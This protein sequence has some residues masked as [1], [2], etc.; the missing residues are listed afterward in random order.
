MPETH[1]AEVVEVIR[2]V[3]PVEYVKSRRAEEAVQRRTTDLA[4][5]V[6]FMVGELRGAPLTDLTTE[7]V[8]R[9]VAAYLEGA[10]AG[11]L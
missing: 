2:A 1:T 3:T 4:D 7:G 10:K 5:F 9:L 8:G 6:Y 11:V